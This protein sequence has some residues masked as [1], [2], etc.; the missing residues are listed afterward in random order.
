M[1][2]IIMILPKPVYEA[3][4]VIYLLMGIFT[5]ST[6]DSSIALISSGLFFTAAT[7]IMYMRKAYRSNIREPAL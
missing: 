3:L 2:N 7:L 6:F 4:P 1:G 5:A